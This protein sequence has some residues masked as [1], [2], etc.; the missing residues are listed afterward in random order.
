[1][2]Q[3]IFIMVIG[4]T[5]VLS[6]AHAGEWQPT[7]RSLLKQQI[8][9]QMMEKSR[10]RRSTE[11]SKRSGASMIKVIGT[12]EPATGLFVD[13]TPAEVRHLKFLRRL[14]KTG[15]PILID[16]AM[17]GLSDFSANRFRN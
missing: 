15:E 17:K 10:E 4:I 3:L 12:E 1:M 16:Q 8:H 14:V 5:G 11:R 9:N 13:A 6:V 2:K 7:P